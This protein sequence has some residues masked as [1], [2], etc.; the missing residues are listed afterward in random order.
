MSKK[1]LAKDGFSF[2]GSVP[3]NFIFVRGSGRVTRI[4]AHVLG[5]GLYS[6]VFFNS[7]QK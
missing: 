2:V 3:R 5:G 7:V 4:L 1:L 6:A